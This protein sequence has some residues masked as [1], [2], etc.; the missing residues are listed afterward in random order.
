MRKGMKILTLVM[1]VVLALG[2]V[3]GGTVA[4]LITNTAPVVNTFTYGDINITLEETDTEKDGDGSPFTNDYSMVPGQKI[5][6]DPKLT[7]L[8]GSEDCWLFVKVEKSANFDDFMTYE[9]AEG[10]TALPGHD[11][12][13]YREVD[14]SKDDQLFTVLKDNMVTVKDTVTKDDMNKLDEDPENV[15]YPT[16]TFTGYA[17]QK[18][19]INTVDAAWQLVLDDQNA[20]QPT[21]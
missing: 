2:A 4:W 10:W 15:N 9:I 18:A 17:V 8:A 16:L 7:V 6:K 21:P 14:T 11:G 13:F 20:A 12:V 19:G 3:V 1:A 5:D